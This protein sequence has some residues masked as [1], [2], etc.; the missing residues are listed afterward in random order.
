MK[1]SE[2]VR[3]NE[4]GMVANAVNLKMMDDPEKNL[5]L[6]QWFIFNYDAQKPKESTV[7]VLVK[8]RESFFGTNNPNVHLI[9]QDY[10]KGKSHFALVVANFFKRSADSEEV[11][12]IFH[13]IEMAVGARRDSYD[14]LKAYKERNKPHLVIRLSGDQMTDPKAAFLKSLRVELD[15]AGVT[16]SIGQHLCADP[17]NFLR[18]QLECRDQVTVDN[19]INHTVFEADRK[20]RADLD[21]RRQEVESRK[22]AGQPARTSLRTGVTI[23]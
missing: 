11:K 15:A 3:I 18:R 7:G 10:G 8:I 22:H 17:L 14:E 21:H 6:C 2:I 20:M 12:G 1:L 4:K 19:D 5:Q 23:R 13:Q 16:E 9:V